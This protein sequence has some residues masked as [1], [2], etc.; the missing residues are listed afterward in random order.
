[1]PYDHKERVVL[2]AHP[3]VYERKLNDGLDEIR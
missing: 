2:E 3:Q 1:M